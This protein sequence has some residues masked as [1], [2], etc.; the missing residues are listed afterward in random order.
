MTA[1][2]LPRMCSNDTIA[3]PV[4]TVVRSSPADSTAYLV[5]C[6]GRPHESA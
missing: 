4:A 6:I 3:L 2:D 5:P 1:S